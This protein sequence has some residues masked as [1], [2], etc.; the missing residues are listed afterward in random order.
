MCL[1]LFVN[2]TGMTEHSQEQFLIVSEC[3]S[4]WNE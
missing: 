2:T 1:S 4:Q 3:R